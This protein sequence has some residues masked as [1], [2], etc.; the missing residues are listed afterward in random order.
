MT[1]IDLRDGAN[2]VRALT[3]RLL[4]A[5]GRPDAEKPL[6]LY[7]VPSDSEFSPLAH[8]VEREVFLAWFDNDAAT[9]DRE[10]GPFEAAS[11]FLLCIDH[12]RREPAG[13]VRL[14]RPNGLGLKTLIDVA[15]APSWGASQADFL[16]HHR[17]AGGM[18]AVVDIASLAVRSAWTG[19]AASQVSQAL[20]AGLYRWSISNSTELLVGALDSAVFELLTALGIPI[21]PLCGLPA[22]EYLGSPSTTPIVISVSEARRRMRVEPELRALL[23]GEDLEPDYSMP[24][25]VLG[26]R[27]VDVRR[28]LFAD[29][30]PP[31]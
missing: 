1:V 28:H 22:A 2:A 14:L 3:S 8:L 5:E 23:L 18:D 29:P 26:G 13:M 20:Y 21:R 25:I 11:E 30:T 4:A 16:A 31:R 10:Y 9:M 12:H 15:V 6:G 17:P 24:P 19:R 27:V 7:F